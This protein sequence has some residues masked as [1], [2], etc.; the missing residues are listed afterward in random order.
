VGTLWLP[1][2]S[3]SGFFVPGVTSFWGLNPVLDVAAYN[4]QGQ[5]W[6][7]V[8]GANSGTIWAD[9]TNLKG[10]TVG[11]IVDP[12]VL[13]A[14]STS[15]TVVH[16]LGGG[17]GSGTDVWAGVSILNFPS[18]PF[19]SVAAS[20]PGNTAVITLTRAAFNAPLG[21]GLTYNQLQVA[22][23]LEG[24]YA[25]CVSA[26]CT[27]FYQG[28]FQFTANEY[29]GALDM[30]SDSQAGEV[31][32]SNVVSVNQF[33]DTIIDRLDSMAS[34]LGAGGLAAPNGEGITVWGSPYGSWNNTAST[35]SGPSYTDSRAGIVLGADLAVPDVPTLVLGVAGNIENRGSFNFKNGNWADFVDD[36]GHGTSSGW[37]IGV[38]GRYTDTTDWDM[39]FYIKGSGT[40]GTYDN[41][42]IRD[43]ALRLLTT[44]SDRPDQPSPGRFT[45]VNPTSPGSPALQ[46]ST[47]RAKFNS[48]V[49]GVYGE[50][51]VNVDVG[52]PD[53]NLT[54][55]VGIRY[56]DST[57]GEF[58]ETSSNTTPGIAAAALNVNDASA[59]AL[60]TYLGAELS[61][62]WDMSNN[63]ALLPSIRLAWAHN[64]EDPWS[65]NAY[66]QGVGPSSDFTIDASTWS[67]DSGLVDVDMSMLFMD[68]LMGTIGYKA[69]I[70]ST[71][72]QQS[73][74][75]RLDVKF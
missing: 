4:Q 73:V 10:G 43:V 39:P 30:L 61:T 68:N 27:S 33:I 41:S 3:A 71:Q 70:N 24:G 36:A 64:F 2:Q 48:T 18:S 58:S 37:D 74:Y 38:Y 23:G 50:G 7:A 17:L 5:L 63:Q 72:V 49:W 75:G 34:V 11:V 44:P 60:V 19:L 16:G 67:R 45:L 54:P 53:L 14:N 65:V 57:S 13:P 20:Y 59:K 56:I 29:P 66:F 42:T 47:M 15:Y 6:L 46:T 51:G 32:Q 12:Y 62:K 35:Q 8:S 55:F 26:A 9:A 52:D 40:Y 22:G 28:I 69:N 1:A 21:V 31:A 25:T